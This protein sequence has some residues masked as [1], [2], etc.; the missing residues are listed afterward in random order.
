MSGP[1][2]CG[3]ESK[4]KLYQWGTSIYISGI[5][6]YQQKRPSRLLPSHFVAPGAM[7]AAI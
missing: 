6:P 4:R 3:I 7:T 1:A 5:T 2:A